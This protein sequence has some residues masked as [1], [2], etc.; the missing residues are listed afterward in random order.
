MTGTDKQALKRAIKMARVE[1]PES[2]GQIDRRM[3]EGQSFEEIGRSAAYGCQC[4]NLRLKPWESPPVYAEL[5]PDQPGALELLNKLLAAGLSRWEPD[6]ITAL[7][8]MTTK[9]APS[10]KAPQSA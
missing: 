7:E 1:S 10:W 4:R 9:P 5:H 3:A 8:A 6:P 2:A